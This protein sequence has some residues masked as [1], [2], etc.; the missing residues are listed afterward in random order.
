M[1]C[2]IFNSAAPADATLLMAAIKRQRHVQL[3]IRAERQKSRELEARRSQH[4]GHAPDSDLDQFW[5]RDRGGVGVEEIS[6]HETHE[7]TLKGEAQAFLFRMF[8]VFRGQI[9]FLRSWTPGIEKFSLGFRCFRL[10]EFLEARIIPKRI[11]HWIEPEERRS[12]R[13]KFVQCAR[14]RYREHLL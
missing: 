12:E 10:G 7:N 14:A 8:S 4:P 2:V 11:E 3:F 9:V 1:S 6:A 13:H 5:I